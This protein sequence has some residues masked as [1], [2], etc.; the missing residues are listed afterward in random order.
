MAILRSLLAAIAVLSFFPLSAFSAKGDTIL[1]LGKNIDYSSD[2]KTMM[3]EFP[4]KKHSFEKMRLEV[5]IKHHE[6]TTVLTGPFI[7]INKTD[8]A[9]KKKSILL[10]ISLADM[11]SGQ[12]NQKLTENE[13][14]LIKKHWKV[15]RLVKK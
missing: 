9:T 3:V 5:E 1:F 4:N 2:G 8:Y 6:G 11:T 7:A 13:I 14:D 10:E 15:W 12:S